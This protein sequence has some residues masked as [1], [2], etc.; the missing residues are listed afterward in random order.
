MPL[1]IYARY[2]QLG[3]ELAE[4]DLA[5]LEMR[6]SKVVDALTHGRARR[7][8]PRA[9]RWSGPCSPSSPPW[10]A[11]E[12]DEGREVASLVNDGVSVTYAAREGSPAGRWARIAREY[13]LGETTADGVPLLYAGVEG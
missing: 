3:G 8:R 10:H 2:Q 6:A 9:R 4:A 13:L 11:E 7:N 5:P 1:L 12:G